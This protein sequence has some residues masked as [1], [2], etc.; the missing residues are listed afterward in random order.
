M[1]IIYFLFLS[2]HI[3]SPTLTALFNRIPYFFYIIYVSLGQELLNSC[4][5][6]NLGGATVKRS[7]KSPFCTHFRSNMTYLCYFFYT[8]DI[9]D[10]KASMEKH[11]HESKD[12]RHCFI[13]NRC[14]C[15]YLLQWATEFSTWECIQVKSILKLGYRGPFPSGWISSTSCH[16]H[17][18]SAYILVYILIK[19]LNLSFRM[20]LN[21]MGLC[22]VQILKEYPAELPVVFLYNASVMIISCIAALLLETNSSAWQLRIDIDLAAILYSVRISSC[23]TF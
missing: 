18:S 2:I 15:C 14:L 4:C 3:P 22:Q 8:F 16:V 7:I 13:N 17:Y 23:Y 5:Y 19:D 20:V 11:E 10:G 1:G 6:M 9:Q 12:H 21:L